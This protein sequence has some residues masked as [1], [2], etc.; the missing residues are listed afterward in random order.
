MGL[1]EPHVKQR[2]PALEHVVVSVCSP[3]GEHRE[4]VVQTLVLQP[5]VSLSRQCARTGSCSTQNA[6]GHSIARRVSGDH[7]AQGAYPAWPSTICGPHWVLE[8]IAQA[9]AAVNDGPTDF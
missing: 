3:H 2:D 8:P 7:G 9:M 5:L 6:H 1:G 4:F